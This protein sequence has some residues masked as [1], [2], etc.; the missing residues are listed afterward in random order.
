MFLE[1]SE[2]NQKP[3]KKNQ[4]QKISLTKTT[5]PKIKTM[6]AKTQMNPKKPTEVSEKELFTDLSFPTGFLAKSFTKI[7]FFQRI[8][9][10]SRIFYSNTKLHHFT[11][12][13]KRI[14]IVDN[15]S[16]LPYST[17]YQP[18]L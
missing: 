17:Q 16:F 14:L 15:G 13:F 9:E 4:I 1:R 7:N 12:K 8:L 11:R 18:I 5:N 2:V 3:T 10:I 6:A